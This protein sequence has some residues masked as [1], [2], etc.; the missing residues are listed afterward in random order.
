MLKTV[1]LYRAFFG[2][3][4][5]LI[6]SVSIFAQNNRL[7]SDLKNSFADFSLVRLADQTV[8]QKNQSQKSLVVAT[9]AGNYELNLTE[10]D[11]RA[12]NYRAENTSKDGAEPLAKSAVTTYKGTIAGANESQVRLTIDEEKIEGYFSSGGEKFYI[13]PASNYSRFADAKDS[14]IYREKDLVKTES[15]VCESELASKIERGA[16]MFGANRFQVL[17]TYQVLEIATEADFSFV[18]ELGGAT[19][20]NNEILSILNLIEGSYETNLGLTFDVVFQHTWTTPDPFDATTVSLFLNSFRSYWNGNYPQTSVPRDIAHLFSSRPTLSGRGLSYVGTVCANPNSAYGFSGRFDVGLI[21]YV[22]AAHEIGHSFNAGHADGVQGC[23]NTVMLAAISNVTPIDFCD[24]SRNEITN[25]AAA[26]GGCLTPRAASRAARFDFDGDAKADIA[27]FRPS[28]SVWYITNSA[29]NSFNFLQFGANGDRVVPADYDGDGKTDVAVYRGGTWFRLK[30]TTNTFDGVNFGDAADIPAPADYDGDAKADIAVFRPSNGV[31]YRL[32][33]Q[34][35]AVASVQFGANGDVPVA[36]DFDS[37]GK[38]D[39]NVFR[40]SSGSWFRLN[41]GNGAFNAVQFGQ[42]GDQPLAGDFD[43]DGKSDTA[44]F[45]P[46]GGGWFALRSSNNS[47]SATAFG[48]STDI[49]AAA[50][51]D[52][53]GK[54]D[55]AVFRP[56]NGT[57]FRLNSSNSA[58]AAT[59]FGANGDAPIAAFYNR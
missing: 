57:W 26:N 7:D 44:V 15:F 46:S 19:N 58:V 45:R 10:R 14:V 40:P 37:D 34:N 22:L 16:Q 42:A 59:Q 41:S 20:A 6:F 48:L 8:S 51:Y 49:P 3:L 1:T 36:A 35:N 53:D 33:S 24:F 28:N 21:K 18:T 11:L 23:A 5:A 2:C 52:G 56:S 43:G 55:I 31:W 39:V 17:P 30:S 9:A 47:F 29:N 27:V 13:E 54:T 32:L 12:T 50:D 25:F 4:C 38:A